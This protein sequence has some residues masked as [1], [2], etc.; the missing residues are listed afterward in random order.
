MKQEL[1]PE[2]LRQDHLDWMP[3]N[4]KK[5]VGQFNVFRLED[6]TCS[7]TGCV[8]YTR[9][10]FYKISLIRG[11][12]KLYYADKAIAFEKSALLF[13]N[14][15]IPYAWEGESADITGFFCVFSDSFFNHDHIKDYPMFK[16][17]ES[18]VFML[19]EEQVPE[20]SRL[21]LRMMEEIESDFTYKYD[22][23]RNLVRELVYSA[24]KMKPA[25][26][27]QYNDANATIRVAS[28]FT[29]LLERQFPVES[30]TRRIQ[31][32][33]PNDFAKQLSIHVNHL[34]RS[35]KETTAKTTSQLIAHRVVQEAKSL[36]MHTDW[37]I[38]QIAWSLGFD[39]LPAFINYFKKIAMVTPL[40]FRKSI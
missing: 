16:P 9:R 14:P 3:G 27:Y 18:P 39:E 7:V 21:Y 26:S 6:L 33:A 5:E 8:P 32:R 11:N 25:S 12:F 4:L 29:E 19:S 24:L 10:D 35:L 22:V 17:G 20:I 2:E 40:A 23:L 37:T 15:Q 1:Q 13:T 38:S 28:L 30:L 34:N 31:F 36:L